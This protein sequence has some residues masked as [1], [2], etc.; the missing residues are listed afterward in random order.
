MLELL[1]ALLLSESFI[2]EALPG[3][4]FYGSLY[5]LASD[6]DFQ[7][8]HFEALRDAVWAR[9]PETNNTASQRLTGLARVRPRPGV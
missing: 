7:V 4:A 3:Q 5:S 9:S 8:R 2:Q 1:L 6:S